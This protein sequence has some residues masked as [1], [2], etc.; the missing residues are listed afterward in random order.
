MRR[1]FIHHSDSAQHCKSREYKYSN[2]LSDKALKPMMLQIWQS[3][4]H[5]SSKQ[6]EIEK[7]VLGWFIILPYFHGLHGKRFSGLD[8]EK[9]LDSIIFLNNLKVPYYTQPAIQWHLDHCVPRP[10]NSW[11]KLQKPP[12]PRVQLIE[13]K[14]MDI[15]HIS[16]SLFFPPDSSGVLTIQKTPHLARCLQPHTKMLSFSFYIFGRVKK[17]K[18]AAWGLRGWNRHLPGVIASNLGEVS[19]PF[20]MSQRAEF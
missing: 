4:T 13:N 6:T 12:W 18:V 11:D 7:T 9:I 17:S 14:W 20:V 19:L 8:V 2:F 3:R 10:K 1:A 5:V 16:K 15:I